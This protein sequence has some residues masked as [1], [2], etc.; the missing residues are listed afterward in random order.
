[1]NYK[2]SYRHLM[3]NAKC[4][5][6]AAVEI[7]NKPRID[8][9]DECFIIL[10]LNAWE[11]A[12]KAVLSKNGRS[13]YYPKRRGEPYR[14]L[15]LKDALSQAESL[16]P[17]TIPPLPVRRNLELLTAYRDNAVHF[18]NA[19][20]FG[21]VIYVLA[22][23]SI[24]NLKEILEQVFG[25]RL[26]EEITWQL[27]PLGLEPPI[28]PIQ[29][30]SQNRPDG[31]NVRP[32]IRRFLSQLANIT[33]ELEDAGLDTGRFLTVF[34]VKL[35]STKKIQRADVVVGVQTP[36]AGGAPLVVTRPVDPNVTHPLRTRDVEQ[37][38]ANLHD[39]KFSSF[40]LQAVLWQY[41]VKA[42]PQ[43]CWRAAEGGLVKYSHDVVAFVRRLSAANVDQAVAAYK[44]HLRNRTAHDQHDSH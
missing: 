38:L 3:R 8:Y 35:E 12:L 40:V 5:L 16:F 42:R 37:Q 26:A 22:Q 44:R 15:S 31:S 36:D 7:Y 11:L 18:Y 24:I 43:Y 10:L 2:G 25:I 34:R 39:R 23:T 21:S 33:H 14:T 30:I 6:L 4:A 41:D 13:I 32:A 28:D 20:G 17:T 1:M 9:R 27:L 19:Q 29:Y